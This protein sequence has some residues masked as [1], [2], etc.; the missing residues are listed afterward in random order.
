V[1]P[2]LPPSLERALGHA[3]VD[4]APRHPQPSAPRVILA[5]ITA[6]AGSLAA[7]LVLVAIGRAVF[8]TTRHF[9]HF[10]LSDY[11]K[12]TVIGVLV[13][14]LAWPVV[15]RIS[16]D[17]RWLFFRQAIAV[18]LV[19]WLPDLYILY[20]GENPRGVA[21]LM[22]MHLAIAL[23][24]YN[25]LVHI[26]KVAPLTRGTPARPARADHYAGRDA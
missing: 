22:A 20:L 3:R 7:D 15:T 12:L 4:F 14:C 18:T 17:P 13:A 19:L 21:V 25:C 16:P 9:A 11:G 24:T 6:L 10:A 8:P 2:R 5:T 1:P 23:V 26:A